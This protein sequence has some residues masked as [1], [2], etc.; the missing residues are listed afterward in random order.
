M[1][2]TGVKSIETARRYI[3]RGNKEL[4]PEICDYLAR[5]LLYNKVIEQAELN[6]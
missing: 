3:I 5:R 1:G 4:R 6:F 2:I